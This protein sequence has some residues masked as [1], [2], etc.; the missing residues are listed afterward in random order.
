MRNVLSMQDLLNKDFDTVIVAAP[1]MHGRLIGKRLAPK[2]LTEFAERGV[3]VSACTFGWDLP[4]NIGYESAY[5]GWHTGW[6]DFLLIPD[7]ST[8]VNAAWL[9]GTAIVLADIV[10]EHDRSPVEITPRRILQRQVAALADRGYAAGVGTELEFHLYR[11]SY[12]ELRQAGYHTRTPSTLIHSDYTVQQVN[13]WEPF[14]RRLRKV[15]DESGMNVEMSQGEWGLGQWEINLTYG[16][17]LDMADRHVLFK[18]A[19]KDVATQAGLSATFLPKP[20]ADGVGSSGHIHLSLRDLA[21][22][23]APA[24]VMWS[25]AEPHHISHTMRQAMGGI[26]ETAPD[27]MAWYAPTINAYRRT[28]SGDFAGHGAT[29]AIDNRTVSC[30][31]LGS[32]PASMRVEWR[33]PGA[34]INPYLAIAGLLAAVGDGIEL[35]IDPGPERKGD[36]YQVKSATE[37]F[38]KNL[39]AAAERFKSSEFIMRHFGPAVLEQYGSAAEWEWECFQHA[40]TDWEL[41]RY[42]ENI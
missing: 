5:A 27:L 35:D 7:M 41:E 16:D 12:D 14:F 29:W 26:L 9:D 13:T 30:R 20:Q 8:L 15:L 4:Q 11:E 1:D 34:D 32:D 31:V 25:D 40:V 36:A 2:R 21:A 24:Q 22:S 37:Q 19:V 6:R 18:L 10:E 23:G 17:A 3:A 33:V 28:N 38:P 42:F 39:G